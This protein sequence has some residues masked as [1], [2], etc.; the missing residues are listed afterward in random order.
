MSA[1]RVELLVLVIVAVAII[2]RR[3]R[4]PYT[5]GL[6]VAG[7]SLGLVPGNEHLVLTRELIFSFLLPPLVFEAAVNLHWR[8]LKLDLPFVILLA[9]VGL[10]LSAGIV[11]LGMHYLAGWPIV[12]CSIF[13]VL[14]SATDPVSVIAAFKES[15]RTG[16]IQ[17]LVE[18]ESLLNDGTAAVAF[19]IALA[20][21]M[22]HQVTVQHVILQFFMIAG[23]GILA[24]A[25]VAGL[26]LFLIGKADD[27]LIEIV[28]TLA[29]AY[30]AFL[31]AEHYQLSGVL[32]TLTAGLMAANLGSLESFS[33]K[34]RAA[35]DSFWEFAAFAA[36]SIVFLLIGVRAT[37][38]PI[39]S[40]PAMVALAI[41]LVLAGRAISVYALSAAVKG[42]NWKVNG[43]GQHLLVWGG[44]RGALALALVLGVPD[45]VPMS[46]AITVVTLGV[47]VFSVVF[48]GITIGPFIKRATT[49]G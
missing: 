21:A 41:L 17:M 16:R 45:S 9:T 49:E 4:L 31:L 37:R 33:E 5:V 3:L 6:V 7:V 40:E 34:G 35:V 48:Q 46:A 28:I 12:S 47:V 42:T 10:A 8:Q 23:G 44:L 29:M 15:G 11:G 32:A 27:P 39:T 38:V 20:A 19:S 18:S 14:I 36:N 43:P 13:A 30:G 2:A 22:G 1:D 24:G 25:L 26:G